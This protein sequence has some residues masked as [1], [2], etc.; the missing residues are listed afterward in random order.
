MSINQDNSQIIET[1][2]KK[3]V[4]LKDVYNFYAPKFSISK[5]GRPTTLTE[6]IASNILIYIAEGIFKKESICKLL[7]L[8]ID[9]MQK[10]FQK[11]YGDLA[12][13]KD[14]IHANFVERWD[15]AVLTHYLERKRIINK[16]IKKGHV[17]LAMKEIELYHSEN[18]SRLQKNLSMEQETT[19]QTVEMTR[20]SLKITKEVKKA[21]MLANKYV[22]DILDNYDFDLDNL[23]ELKLNEG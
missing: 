17:A 1:E 21:R 3:S 18:D 10:W 5:G 15:K 23:E 9:T 13:N 6:D 14:T 4:S 22:D 16:E 12:K 2:V 20:D 7:G 11:G 19:T 8:N